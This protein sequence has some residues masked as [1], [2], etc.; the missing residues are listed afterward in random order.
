MCLSDVDI[1]RLADGQPLPEAAAHAAQC[2][3]CAARVAARRRLMDDL[4]AAART[5]ELPPARAAAIRRGL[6]VDPRADARSGQAGATTLRARPAHRRPRWIA[7]A[8]A[9]AATLLLVTVVPRLDRT[10]TVTAA[11]I[12]GRTREALASTQSGIETLTYDLALEGVLAQLLPA[13]QSG[14]FT[15]EEVIDHDHVGRFR[16]L[17]LTAD[18]T[19]VAGAVEDPVAGQRARYIRVHGRG[20]LL[21]FSAAEPLPLTLPA[22]KRSALQAFVAVMQAQPQATVTEISRGA[23]RVF[24][25]EI[26]T[27]PFAAAAP[28]ALSR[29]RAVIAADDARLLEVDAAGTVMDQ[30]FSISF[31]L[32]GRQVRTSPAAADQFEIPVRADDVI[33]EGAAA[34][35]NPMWDVLTRALRD[36]DRPEPAR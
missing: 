29:G 4:A 12:L 2:G 19:A 3:R 36:A 5:L 28:F 18:G 20:Y 1:Q 21:R 14:R 25:V 15:V 26:P 22:I 27:A 9:A 30:P 17:K 32:R 24:V 13:E 23:Q 16:V 33:L 11:E 8:G 31:V 6:A 34:T 35:A 10:E 7:L